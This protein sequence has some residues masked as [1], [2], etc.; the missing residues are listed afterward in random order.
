M[1]RRAAQG[2]K[3]HREVSSAPTPVWAGM[4]T[5]ITHQEPVDVHQGEHEEQRVEE[6]VEGDVGDGLEAGVAGG[7]EHLEGEP[8]ETEPEPA[9]AQGQRGFSAPLAGDRAST[10]SPAALA[11]QSLLL[12]KGRTAAHPKGLVQRRVRWVG[13]PLE[14]FPSPCTPQLLTKTSPQTEAVAHPSLHPPIPLFSSRLAPG[15]AGI[16]DSPTSLSLPGKALLAAE[17]REWENGNSS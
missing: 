13:K 1:Q 8:V 17:P 12:G 10:A 5:R 11:P 3:V 4:A 6:E 16:W 14:A 9:G 15:G 7:V 2:L